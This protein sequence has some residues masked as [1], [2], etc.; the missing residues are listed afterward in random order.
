MKSFRAVILQEY[1]TGV[2]W[3]VSLRKKIRFSVYGKRIT[4]IA[5]LIK[6][7]VES[8]AKVAA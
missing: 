2:F 1:Q 5:L 3:N 7:K 4:A 6:M 8:N